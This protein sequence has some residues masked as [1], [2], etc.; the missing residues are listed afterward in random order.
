MG[1]AD[2]EAYLYKRVLVPSATLKVAPVVA[3]LPAA[4]ES[5]AD[6]KLKLAAIDA[7]P[8]LF[9]ETPDAYWAEHT[10][11]EKK[12]LRDGWKN[13]DVVRAFDEGEEDAFDGDGGQRDPFGPL[14]DALRLEL[15]DYRDFLKG[16][17]DLYLQNSAEWGKAFPA[18][19]GTPL[20]KKVNARYEFWP[21][22]KKQW[23]ILY[24]CA[25]Q[26]LAGSK[27]TSTSNERMHAVAGRIFSKLR[28]SLQ[29][30]NLEKLTLAYYYIRKEVER[31]LSKWVEQDET[32]LD[33]EDLCNV[34]EDCE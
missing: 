14:L 19:Y 24:F 9:P 33:L 25:T 21:L 4:P 1:L 15:A 17:T 11:S 26:V 31:L 8:K 22:R 3:A 13:R 18:P 32:N 12:K 29:P 34:L 30:C 7:L 16:Q 5:L 20:G 10:T 27:G 28:G 2:V 6:L 23:P